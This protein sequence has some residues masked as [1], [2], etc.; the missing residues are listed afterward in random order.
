MISQRLF[1]NGHPAGCVEIRPMSRPIT[2]VAETFS[3]SMRG[4]LRPVLSYTIDPQHLNTALFKKDLLS[5]VERGRSRV[6]MLCYLLEDLAR[7][8]TP[9]ASSQ[10]P[11]QTFART[12]TLIARENT[13]GNSM[14]A[15]ILDY[16]D[17]GSSGLH[18]GPNLPCRA[19]QQHHQ[20]ERLVT[21]TCGQLKNVKQEPVLL[22]SFAL[23]L[24]NGA[25]IWELFDI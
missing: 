6:N 21:V 5:S 14:G 12:E 17:Y 16:L 15:A 2:K 24:H 25:N 10:R 11:C 13:P 1:I 20:L 9:L 19:S 7:D 18:Y 4:Q 3:V 22:K 8:C 23:N